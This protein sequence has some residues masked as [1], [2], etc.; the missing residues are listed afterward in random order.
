[1]SDDGVS[2]EERLQRLEQ[3]NERILS[4]LEKVVGSSFTYKGKKLPE[5]KPDFAKVEEAL[6][7]TVAAPEL[8]ALVTLDGFEAREWVAEAKLRESFVERSKT[9]WDK[10]Y[11]MVEAVSAQC[12]IPGRMAGWYS[13]P[14]D[15]RRH[16]GSTLHFGYSS[17]VGYDHQNDFFT[18]EEV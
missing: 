2:I 14:E 18:E 17:E 4:L 1:M 16:I 8:S 10:I 3:Q 9:N 13:D 6:R 15:W 7:A 11:A 12:G 5:E